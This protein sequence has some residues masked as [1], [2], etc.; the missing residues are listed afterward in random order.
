MVMAFVGRELPNKGTKNLA[1]ELAGNT[2]YFVVV[3]ILV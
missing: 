3:D 2:L 1:S